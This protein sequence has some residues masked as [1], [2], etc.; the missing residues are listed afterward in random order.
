MTGTLAALAALAGFLA[1]FYAL[2]RRAGAVQAR[3]T[4]EEEIHAAVEKALAARERLRHDA[5]YA[6]RV[7]E[8]FTR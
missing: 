1:L 2:A 7:R 3:L 5:D 6:R 8:R 4:K